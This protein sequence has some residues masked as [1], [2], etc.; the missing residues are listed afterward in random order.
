VAGLV[1]DSLAVHP[2][3]HHALDLV[4]GPGETGAAYQGARVFGGLDQAGD[5][6][7]FEAVDRGGFALEADEVPEEAGNGRVTADLVPVSFVAG[8]DQFQEVFAGSR[9]ERAEIRARR[10]R[11]RRRGRAP[12]FPSG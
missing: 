9:R 2:N 6:E 12:R 10:P 7:R 5:Q 4:V 11:R 3:R 8:S 1:E